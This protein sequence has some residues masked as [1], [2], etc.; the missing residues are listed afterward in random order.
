MSDDRLQETLLL[1]A[2]EIIAALDE[3]TKKLDEIKQ[4]IAK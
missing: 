1:A 2:K 3:I 4:V